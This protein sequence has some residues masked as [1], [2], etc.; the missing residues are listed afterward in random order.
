METPPGREFGG[1]AAT[2]KEPRALGP[3]CRPSGAKLWGTMMNAEPAPER[4][5][6]LSRI[7]EPFGA[8]FS[9]YAP[10]PSPNG[11]T[12]SRRARGGA[13]A[14]AGG[15]FSGRTK[16]NRTP[17]N[18]PSGLGLRPHLHLRHYRGF[19][20]LSRR[21]PVSS[22]RNTA[23]GQS[24]RSAQS[25]GP[26][27]PSFQPRPLALE[28]CSQPSLLP[29][30]MEKSRKGKNDVYCAPGEST[31]YLSPVIILE[32]LMQEIFSKNLRIVTVRTSFNSYSAVIL[33]SS[34]SWV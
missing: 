33:C 20:R 21:R 22:H 11:G 17:V 8:A 27:G 9:Y 19:V 34:I 4:A 23:V 16:T 29:E 10:R 2:R 30:I 15:A 6:P 7:R 32:L 25:H 3:A 12:S 1:P 18:G 31:I 14:L 28:S 26:K 24:P 13:C 5:P